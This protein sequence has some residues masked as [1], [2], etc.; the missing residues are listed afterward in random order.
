MSY[1]VNN[2]IMKQEI[3]DLREQN[4]NILHERNLAKQLAIELINKIEKL[5]KELKDAKQDH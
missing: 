2:E 5:E 4:K 3:Q 1:A